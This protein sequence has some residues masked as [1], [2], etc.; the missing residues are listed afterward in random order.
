VRAR[1]KLRNS[2]SVSLSELAVLD[3]S[4]ALKPLLRSLGKKALAGSRKASGETS[5]SM[6]VSVTGQSAGQVTGIEDE[7]VRPG[8]AGRKVSGARGIV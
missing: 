1:I 5:A 6:M 7:H 8:H 3:V 2:D 4:P